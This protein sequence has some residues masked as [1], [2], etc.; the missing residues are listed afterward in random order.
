MSVK[1]IFRGDIHLQ[2]LNV[3]HFLL[4]EISSYIYI[5]SHKYLSCKYQ[6]SI[7]HFTFFPNYDIINTA[8]KG[9]VDYEYMEGKS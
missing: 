4:Y 3:P 7:Y 8:L 5:L 1:P 9:D 6:K 2:R